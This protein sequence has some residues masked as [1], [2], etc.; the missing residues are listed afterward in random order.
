[1]Q[2]NDNNLLSGYQQ[3]MARVKDALDTPATLTL[4]EHI[5]AAKEKA[6]ALEE[7]SVEEAERV[8]H[9]L[10]RDLQ[11]AAQFV[12][13]TEQGLNEWIRFDLAL[14]EDKLLDMFRVMVD[15]TH[16][17]LDNLAERARLATEWTSG[18]ITG[19]GTLQC[20]NCQHSLQ[21][22]QPAYIPVCPNCGATLFKRL[23]TDVELD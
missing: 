7:L 17:E 6:V 14:I 8:G 10:W 4:R 15:Q 5:E 1:M 19:P 3:M 18:E 21:F 13:E 22:T 16:Q 12:A 9:Y 20:D 23:T 2:H 11:D